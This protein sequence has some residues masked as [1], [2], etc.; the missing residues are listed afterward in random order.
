MKQQCHQL[1]LSAMSLHYVIHRDMQIYLYRIALAYLSRQMLSSELNSVH[2]TFI[3][4]RWM[5]LLIGSLV[6][7]YKGQ[8]GVA[9]QKGLYWP[10]VT[11]LQRV[12]KY[13]QFSK[14]F[15]YSV[16]HCNCLK[17]L[18]E[19]RHTIAIIIY[20]LYLETVSLWQYTKNIRHSVTIPAK[21][22][23]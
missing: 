1:L 18:S 23:K 13:S 15:L 14:E 6:P 3:K 8:M 17:N 5:T 11:A 22:N 2:H 7:V 4:A 16:F 19:L 20:N 9:S 12:M 21:E 10:A